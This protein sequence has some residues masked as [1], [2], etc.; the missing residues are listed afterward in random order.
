M[1]D[2]GTIYEE[3]RRDDGMAESLS[4]CGLMLKENPQDLPSL[5]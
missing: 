2:D 4:S 3:V 5:Q 1:D